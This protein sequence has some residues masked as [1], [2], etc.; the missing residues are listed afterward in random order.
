MKKTVN[1]ALKWLLVFFVCITTFN[2]S[3]FAKETM[4]REPQ[5]ELEIQ[6]NKGEEN[7]EKE[8]VKIISDFKYKDLDEQIVKK[9]IDKEILRGK[10]QKETEE[11]EDS[12]PY[13][14]KLLDL[15]NTY[16][17]TQLNNML[18]KFIKAQTDNGEIEIPIT[19][20]LAEMS[21]E[22]QEGFYML[23]PEIPKEYELS[24]SKSNNSIELTVS[25]QREKERNKHATLSSNKNYNSTNRLND[26]VTAFDIKWYNTEDT[27]VV[28]NTTEN[29]VDI[30]V[31]AELTFAVSQANLEK[32]KIEIRLP[33]KLFTNRDN[34]KQGYYEVANMNNLSYEV[35]EDKN[36][37]EIIITNKVPII[38]AHTLK[39]QIDYYDSDPGYSSDSTFP[40]HIVNNSIHKLKAR[41][42]IDLGSETI[43]DE[44]KE[45]QVKHII[46]TKLKT[47]YHYAEEK[48]SWDS[49]W[50]E[51]PEN[52][53]FIRYNFRVVFES[54]P[55]TMPYRLTLKKEGSYD[56][57]PPNENYDGKV[58]MWNISGISHE[59]P[60]IT[61]I[62]NK[63][64]LIIENYKK[65]NDFNSEIY[66]K[67]VVAYPKSSLGEEASIDEKLTL[68]L[69][70]Y[71][72]ADGDSSQVKIS[73]GGYFYQT[74][75]F[76]YPPGNYDIDKNNS[77]GQGSVEKVKG[78]IDKIKLVEDNTPIK[79]PKYTNV[80]TVWG[81][82]LT[83]KEDGNPDA[84]EDYE[85][86]EYT[87][88]AYDDLMILNG[89]RLL[90]GDYS[91]PSVTIGNYKY[92]T[93]IQNED[94]GGAEYKEI[95]NHEE[96]QP[97]D[98]YYS[99]SIDQEEWIKYATVKVSAENDY[100]VTY[101]NGQT[102]ESR[103][104]VK[105]LLPEHT[106]GVK[107]ITKS[108]RAKTQ[109]DLDV[110]INL[111]GTEHLK[112]IMK[113]LEA[114]NLS[115]I[116]LYNVST[117]VVK[118]SNGEW[119]N[120]YKPNSITGSLKEIVA[121]HDKKIYGE[122]FRAQH[123][124][125]K[126][127]LQT[128][129][130][131]S[132]LNKT[133]KDFKTNNTVGYF[134]AQCL[135]DSHNL[136]EY[137]DDVITEEDFRKYNLISE[138]SHGKIY[139]LLPMGVFIDEKSIKTGYAAHLDSEY[140]V[141]FREIENSTV[142]IEYINNWK[143]SGRTMA[144]FDIK[145]PN[146]YDNIYFNTSENYCDSSL[147]VQFNLI[148]PYESVTD[149][150]IDLRNLAAYESENELFSGLPDNGDSASFEN[151]EK[152][153]FTD[154]NNDG[155]IGENAPKNMI[156][157]TCDK[158]LSNPTASEINFSKAVKNNSDV[159]YVKSTDVIPNEKY[160]YK[161]RIGSEANLDTKDIV[162]FDVLETAYN[163]N[164][165][166]WQG[167]LENVDVSQPI[168][169]GVKPVIYYSVKKDI[170]LNNDDVKNLSGNADISDVSIW[171]T[172]MPKDKESI[173]AVAVDLR[174]KNDGTEFVLENNETLVVILNM[175]APNTGVDEYVKNKAKAYNEGWLSNSVK[176][177]N[178]S[179]YE[180][181]A[182]LTNRTEV[183]IRMQDIWI[184]K[185]SDPES[186]TEKTPTVVKN[187]DSIV[188]DVMIHNG[189]QSNSLYNI[190][191]EDTIPQ[192][193]TIDFDNIKYYYNY[194]E[195]KAK[196]VS[197]PDDGIAAERDKDNIQKLIF[198]IDELEGYDYIHFLIPTTVDTTDE[199]A[200]YENQAFI[201]EIDG[202]ECVEESRITYHEK[203]VPLADF[204][205]IKKN[206]QDKLLPD[207]KFVLYEVDC[208]DST[209]N[210][211]E[212][213]LEVDKNGDLVGNS[214][215]FKNAKKA[216][217]ASDGHVHFTD[218]KTNRKYRLIEYEAPGEYVTPKGQWIVSY[219]EK[220]QQFNVSNSIGNPPGFEESGSDLI[221]R[222]YKLE[223][224][225]STGGRGWT[226]YMLLGATVM[227]IGGVWVYQNK[228]RKIKRL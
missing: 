113:D 200:R 152:E 75:E 148:Y 64:G 30:K 37:N 73:Y 92:Y 168:S 16:T 137:S 160:S 155:F 2:L 38:D 35:N 135:I 228:K 93:V 223:E 62:D 83:L 84:L 126:I 53:I 48:V 224:L 102:T 196:L 76:K 218:L 209:H 19:W 13:E 117:I 65:D 51:K 29:D 61:E 112:K 169:K 189:E 105:V 179:G 158:Q 183:S 33:A 220:A 153:W 50:G 23:K 79:L 197:L 5:E 129:E 146:E 213:L 1:K 157:A 31:R 140:Y 227:C 32:G 214:E 193:L 136:I 159:K 8:E 34:E 22:I 7:N 120:D 10:N 164:Q 81:G 123:D 185:Y 18:P 12:M 41:Y 87:M 186:G 101:T 54:T 204:D 103:G 141:P 177:E 17:K 72:E 191:V 104:A 21:E 121:E 226:K 133:I 70:P 118:D 77:W 165:Y 150:G 180:K 4:E 188:Y 206:K 156:Y 171:T 147:A 162:L 27:E 63:N 111:Y 59:D 6:E 11:L 173:T 219:D 166:W 78:A 108:K 26:V 106:V 198:K 24:K 184:A 14:L 46:D 201:T 52:S 174:K 128:L 161:L 110:E 67:F 222:N 44:T 91:F 20:E 167:T 195:N 149:Y 15:K 142:S 109:F 60:H 90:P 192:G 39:V 82:E 225:P 163:D 47:I 114:E 119:V 210:H 28:M 139:D 36:N 125:H 130:K 124:D 170:K 127:R 203:K 3:I 115:S 69:T 190:V 9:K 199:A 58:I 178:N 100:M 182:G 134:Y 95:T 144:I 131:R 205:F 42:S 43:S 143:N 55:S 56:A 151:I 74:L 86:R 145:I 116:D 207:A 216:S 71:Y 97:I 66:I 40:S 175:K 98:I 221:I 85:Q 99:T 217:S 215:C 187:G 122:N 211:E 208:K 212:D 176:L 88:D 57:Y 96:K 25:Y 49:S 89:E 154:I 80:A 194:D 138:E 172:E 45:I 202:I 94:T 68:T 132:L 107:A 181:G